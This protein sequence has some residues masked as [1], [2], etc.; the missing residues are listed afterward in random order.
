MMETKDRQSVAVKVSLDNH[1][2]DLLEESS[3]QIM[4]ALTSNPSTIKQLAL[5]FNLSRARVKFT[6]DKLMQRGLVHVYREV[7]ESGRT[8]VYYT[9]VA[10]DIILT[11]D[12]DSSQY[13]QL[14]GVQVIFNSLQTNVIKALADLT[15]E[16]VIM[17]KLV[18]CRIPSA[19][20][21]AFAARLE[22]LA[23]EFGEAEEETSEE[24]FALVLALYPALDSQ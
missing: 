3:L 8:E 22:E 14:A 20:A 23:S 2:T 19:K 6:V 11:L 12:S 13:A 9:A 17:L 4:S 18:Q 21:R 16:N 7:Q 24:E 15:T 1:E 10:K 5:R